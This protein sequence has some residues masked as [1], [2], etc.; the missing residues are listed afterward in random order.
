MNEGWGMTVIESN[1]C[2][3]PAV[4]Y[5][6]SGLEESISDGKSGLLAENDEA[7]ILHLVAVLSDGELRNKL[8]RGAIDWASSFDWDD[9]AKQM[10]HTLERTAGQ[11]GD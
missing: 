2:G 6:V 3:T 4:A 11:G 8:S 10:L 9:T 7:F 1:A 5:R